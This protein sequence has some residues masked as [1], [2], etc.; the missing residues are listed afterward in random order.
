MNL[1][2]ASRP[3]ALQLMTTGFVLYG[4]SNLGVYAMTRGNERR[5][6]GGPRGPRRKKDLKPRE[7]YECPRCQ[8]GYVSQ[9]GHDTQ[10][11]AVYRCG[12]CNELMGE[13]ALESADRARR[14]L[15]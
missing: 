12:V 4:R 10:K 6:R 7:Y 14:M 2:D 15:D 8:R 5:S 13:S 11:V 9:T 3:C 1:A